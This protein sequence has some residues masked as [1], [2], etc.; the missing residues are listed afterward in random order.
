M[1][2]KTKFTWVLDKDDPDF[3]DCGCK[4]Y[5]CYFGSLFIGTLYK[6]PGVCADFYTD[7]F[8]EL[9]ALRFTDEKDLKECKKDVETKTREFFRNVISQIETQYTKI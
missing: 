4:V 2:K 3:G 5:L 8:P 1:K 7:D 6:N 9:D